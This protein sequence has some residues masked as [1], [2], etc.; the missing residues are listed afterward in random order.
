MK[1]L[2]MLVS[3]MILSGCATTQP[4]HKLAAPVTMQVT[5]YVDNDVTTTCD[6]DNSNGG[7]NMVCHSE[8]KQ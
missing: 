6:E 3:V 7:T 5:V 4:S 2:M 1:A 8:V